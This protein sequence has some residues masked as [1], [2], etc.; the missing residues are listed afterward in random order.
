VCKGLK[1]T[2]QNVPDWGTN[3][4]KKT[5]TAAELKVFSQ[6]SLQA[7]FKPQ[8]ILKNKSCIEMQLF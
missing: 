4:P 2:L 3:L 7:V 5:E 6:S 8:N 1:K